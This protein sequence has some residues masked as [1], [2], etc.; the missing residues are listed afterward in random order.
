MVKKRDNVDFFPYAQYIGLTFFVALVGFSFITTP[1]L[2]GYVVISSG[3]TVS[4]GSQTIADPSHGVA[5]GTLDFTLS[6]SGTVIGTSLGNNYTLYFTKFSISNLSLLK[7][8]TSSFSGN[9]TSVD[10][11]DAAT[12]CS[13]GNYTTTKMYYDANGN[14][15]EDTSEYDVYSIVT[16]NNGCFAVKVKAGTNNI[17]G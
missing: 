6:D 11:D 14:S 17:Y 13:S 3:S 4:A 16:D 10:G 7:T 1:T 12:R 15:V 5:K 8:S 2:T 9:L